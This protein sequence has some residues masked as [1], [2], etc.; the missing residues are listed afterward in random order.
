M[1][2]GGA[3]IYVPDTLKAL[4]DI[5]S[6]WAQKANAFVVAITG[7]VGK[8]ST[9][10]V[11][12]AVVGSQYKTL[13]TQGN[14]NNEVGLPL[15][16]LDYKNEEAMVLEMGMNHLG[17]LSVLTRIARPNI[18]VIT[19]VGTA[20]IGL[21][22]SRE[23]ILKAKLEITEGL[24]PGG[25]LIIN[26]DNDMLQ[27]YY[28]KVK[29]KKLPYH[30]KTFGIHTQSDVMAK[31]VVLGEYGSSFDYQDEHFEVPVPGEHFV[32]NALSAIAVG[33]CMD[34]P[35]E[36][37]RRAIKYFELTKNRMDFIELKNYIQIIDGSYNA[38]LDS[39][40]SSLA[41]L[42][43]YKKRR[44]IAVLADMLELGEYSSELHFKTGEAVD[45]NHIDLLVCIGNESKQIIAG[46]VHTK[47]KYWFENNAMALAFLKKHLKEDDIVLVKGSNS[48]H[49]KELINELKENF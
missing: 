16:I 42:G 9:R 36:R 24:K 20:H 32:L 26:H 25:T 49:L 4:Q 27:N 44:K 37:M 7:S 2:P 8:T 45:K 6:Y 29:N 46:A 39:M 15:T 10:D 48:M 13:K 33:E 38:N 34:I 35:L 1:I 14:Y 12:G 17:E 43:R 18:A 19:N 28:D 11:I 30:I 5:A 47:R 41:V 40:V 3:L 21:L 23:N 31:N 22:G